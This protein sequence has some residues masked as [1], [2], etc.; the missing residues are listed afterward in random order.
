VAATNGGRLADLANA[1]L[2]AVDPDKPVDLA[3]ANVGGADPTPQQIEEAKG[4][5]LRRAAA[6]FDDPQVR[7]TLLT[8][9]QRNEQIIDVTSRDRVRETGFSVADTYR[10]RATVESFQAFVEEHRDEITALQII[11]TRPYSQRHLTY[12][13]VKELAKSL[14]Q[15]P[16]GWT[17]EALWRAYAQ[18]ERDRVRG[19]G[20]KRVLTD[21][22]SLV[23]HVVQPQEELV[24]YLDLVRERYDAW[25]AANEAS[26]RS[27]TPAQ[28]WWL[29]RIA[30]HI[31]V[32]LTI[33]PDD[34]NMGEFY[35]KGGQIGALR[36][37]GKDLRGLLDELNAALAA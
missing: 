4:T 29:D 27:F 3:R 22:V 37:F 6:P 35:S 26:G 25:L 5:L 9:H 1:L 23:R 15:P 24:P 33:T 16:H 10:A 11:Y 14:E 18:V 8:F 34:L 19:A 32:N 7:A 31:G 28:R 21:L 20:A 17:A 13:Q 12:S 2:D 30:G 36:V